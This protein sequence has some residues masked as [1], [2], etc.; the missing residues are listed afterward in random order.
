MIWVI[1]TSLVISVLLIYACQKEII[2]SPK[3]IEKTIENLNPPAD[4]NFSTVNIVEVNFSTSFNDAYAVVE[5]YNT[6]PQ[7]GGAIVATAKLENNQFKQN[8]VLPKYLESVYIRL[9]SNNGTSKYFNVPIVDDKANFIYTPQIQNKSAK[10]ENTIAC[11]NCTQTI[12]NSGFYNLT[13]NDGETVC[14]EEGA[15][16]SGGINM[17][18]GT[19]SVCGNVSFSYLNLNGSPTIIIGEQGNISI[20]NFN[21]NVTIINYSNNF[22]LPNTINGYFE[23][24]GTI[25]RSGNLTVNYGA[26]I[27]NYGD[28]TISGTLMNNGT[29]ENSSILNAGN[30]TQNTSGHLINNCKIHSYGNVVQ[31]SSFFENNSFLKVDGLLQINSGAN[32][33]LNQWALIDCQN[34]NLYGS[35]SNE[36][37]NYARVDIAGMT[38]LYS[39]STIDGLVD[40]C[41]EN[42]IELTQGE[43]GNDIQFCQSAIPETD[44]NPGSG[45]LDVSDDD[46]DGV[47]NSID[48]FSTDPDRAFVVNY[49]SKDDG[50]FAFE[51]LWP[52]KGDYDFNDV[53]INFQYQMIC[54]AIGL[55]KEIQYTI[56][57]MAV[58]GAYKNGFGVELPV[59]SSNIESH[60]GNFSLSENIISLNDVNIEANQTKAVLIFFDNAL[61]ELVHPGNGTIGINTENGTNYSE[62]AVF[63][64]NITFKDPVDILNDAPFNPFIFVNGERGREVHLAGQSGTSLV[65]V[66][67]FG[68]LDD[69]SMNGLNYTTTQHLPW[70]LSFSSEFDYPIEKVEIIQAYLKFFE[71]AN[72]GGINFPDW[73]LQLPSYR[74]NNYVYSY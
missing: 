50:T 25:N 13:I 22:N 17:N 69:N 58:G 41:D 39:G 70:A 62:P 44:C 55:V 32:L 6:D 71:W 56:K 68:T 14:I 34:F 33:K 4:F 19:L 42:G 27:A 24:Y 64:G 45:E 61:H 1:L 40:I 7:L 3:E 5:V 67:L 23:N 57:L 60:T 28:I 16:V 54:N 43:Q 10:S 53:V 47:V 48:L 31:M 59:E 29:V 20:F 65:D 15:T 46:D 49:P 8:I 9:K 52:A 72:S 74:D 12:S 2:E 18:G 38:Q 21:S 26:T 51:D 11:S 66:N 36:S 37:S 73:Y 35:L 63:T 30:I